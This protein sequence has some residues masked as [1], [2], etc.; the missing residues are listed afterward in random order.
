MEREKYSEVVSR[1]FHSARGIEPLRGKTVEEVFSNDEEKRIFIENL[2]SEDFFE[3]LNSVNGI[4]RGR[5]KEEWDMDGKGVVLRGALLGTEYV[6]PRHED[7]PELLTEVLTAAKEMNHNKR[8][9]EDIGLL[10][11]SALNAIH[12]YADANGRTS[13]LMYL[14]LTKNF[15]SE[16]QSELSEILGLY[17]RDKFDVNP[18]GSMQAAIENFIE[19]D[20][21]LKNPEMNVD[22]I[23]NL[24]GYK[25][26]IQFNEEI[27]QKDQDLF[28]ELLKEDGHD[29]FLSVFEYLQQQKD[30]E[31]YIRRF[32]QRA[33]VPIS[34]FSKNV[35]QEGLGQILQNYWDLKKQYV[36]ILIDVIAHPEKEKYQVLHNNES[37]PLKDYFKLK[38]KERAEEIAKEDRKNS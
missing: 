32:P 9:F 28:S 11:S 38:I 26:D 35:T 21:G 6:P 1:F 18:R 27:P 25:K 10:V 34:L 7:K 30:R 29:L 16:A 4:L 5:K 19:D 17:G 31:K 12:P 36:R 3:V 24:F 33:A 13:R 37:M 8:S 2:Q 23:T 14:L 22:N 15:N 20:I